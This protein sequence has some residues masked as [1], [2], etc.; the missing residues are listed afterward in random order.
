MVKHVYSV[1]GAARCGH[2]RANA[3]PERV[4]SGM[5]MEFHVFQTQIEEGL[6]R[7]RLMAALSGLFGALAALLATIGLYGVMAYVMVR[8]NEIGIRMALGAGRGSV[9]GL[10][11]KD[12]A[13]LLALAAAVGGYLPARRASRLGPMTALRYE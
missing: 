1:L 10:V 4:T 2:L 6:V 5:A 8:R 9:I 11:M 13:L 3:P 12:A 7:E